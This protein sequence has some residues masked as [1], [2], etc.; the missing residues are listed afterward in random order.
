MARLRGL[1][2]QSEAGVGNP[3]KAKETLEEEHSSL[4]WRSPLVNISGDSVLPLKIARKH[5]RR[6]RAPP[7]AGW[8]GSSGSSGLLALALSA[9]CATSFHGP[10]RVS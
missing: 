4:G 7:L 3:W 10:V 8:G 6:F 1:K 5:L 2:G 9:P